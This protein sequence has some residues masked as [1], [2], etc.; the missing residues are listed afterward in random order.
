MEVHL[1]SFI[2]VVVASGQVTKDEITR[3]IN[4]AYGIFA[5]TAVWDNRIKEYTPEKFKRWA[6][7][8]PGGGEVMIFRTKNRDEFLAAKDGV[9][10]VLQ[11]LNDDAELAGIK[12]LVRGTERFYDI[13]GL[14]EV[15]RRT[16]IAFDLRR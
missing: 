15:G 12:I 1:S 5:E 7:P 6:I 3:F 11:A 13:K 10:D 8:I 4:E 2:P 14:E 9:K 16:W